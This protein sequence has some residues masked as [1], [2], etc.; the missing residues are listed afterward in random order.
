[1]GPLSDIAFQAGCH[2][3]SQTERNGE[4]EEEGEGETSLDAA[5]WEA[6]LAR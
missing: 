6:A 1:M 3:G 2:S 4:R 5:S